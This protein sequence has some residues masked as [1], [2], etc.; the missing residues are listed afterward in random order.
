MLKKLAIAYG[1][2]LAKL[3]GIAG[4]L[5]M[6]DKEAE[7]HEVESLYQEA[8]VDPAFA[9]G[10]RARGRISSETKKF[11]AEMYRELKQQRSGK[12]K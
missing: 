8:V 6:T 5:E 3:M 11:I 10:R 4:Y 2:E 12:K 1:E 9:F 7:A